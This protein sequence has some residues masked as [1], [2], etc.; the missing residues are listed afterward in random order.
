VK[1]LVALDEERAEWV[2]NTIQARWL[3]KGDRNT[4]L[5]LG[6]HKFKSKSKE[7]FIL[8]IR[9]LSGQVVLEWQQI[10][11]AGVE[12]YTRMFA[13]KQNID[14]GLLED[15]LASYKGKITDEE[16]YIMDTRWTL[17]ELTDSTHK[18]AKNR[19]PGPDSA[20]VE[21]LI[22]Q[23]QI[24]GPL[25]LEALN[26]GMES[27]KLEARMPAGCI[28]VIPKKGP[29][30]KFANKRPITALNTPYKIG[31]KALSLGLAS[32]AKQIISTS[33]SGFLL[34][35]SIHRSLLLNEEMM[36]HAK[37][38]EVEFFLMSA[39]IVKVFDSVEWDF[40]ACNPQESQHR[41][42]VPLL[43]HRHLG[44]CQLLHPDQWL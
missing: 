12:Y 16:K 22:W 27:G 23:W 34:G 37:M 17:L 7:T 35:R 32:V 14:K 30:D 25:V 20:P 9:N 42:M 40:L 36:Y 31:A 28:I 4:K 33:Q 44:F 1:Q 29:Q 2:S 39:D 24:L 11:G 8:Q 6:Q 19:A 43:S 21:F 38:A 13:S 15:I 3:I 5:F 18:M 26:E 41:R 10:A